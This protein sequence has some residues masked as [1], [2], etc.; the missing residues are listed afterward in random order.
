M[1]TL[2]KADLNSIVGQR[3]KDAAFSD[4]LKKSVTAEKLQAQRYDIFLSHSSLDRDTVL[5]LNY[6]LEEVYGF[7]VFVDWI[8]KPELDRTRVTPETA[9]QI[10]DAMDRS[11]TLV[12]AVSESSAVSTWMPWELGYSDARH[13]RVAVLPI[14]GLVTTAAAYANQQFVGLYPVIDIEKIGSTSKRVLW[15]NDRQNSRRYAQLQ[16]WKQTGRL[17]DHPN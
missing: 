13:G 14:S 8:E 6:L 5:Q 17:N 16:H 11:E 7:E 15:V 12:Y 10:R 9:E 2:S 3:Y 4:S 1:A